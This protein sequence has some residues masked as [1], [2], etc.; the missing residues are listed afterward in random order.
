MYTENPNEDTLGV[1]PHVL[2]TTDTVSSGD[3][4]AARYVMIRNNVFAFDYPDVSA[5]NFAPIMQIKAK[6]VAILNNTAI[7]S[8]SESTNFLMISG[9]H[10]AN[11]EL[12]RN[13]FYAPNLLESDGDNHSIVTLDSTTG[14]AG[15][16]AVFSGVGE[17]VWHTNDPTNASLIRF[18]VNGTAMDIGDWN[19]ETEVAPDDSSIAVTLNTT[20][21]RPSGTSADLSNG[22]SSLPVLADLYGL[23]RP[24][25]G[26]PVSLTV[27]AV[28]RETAISG[29]G[30]ADSITLKRNGSAL[31]IWL[32][33]S[34]AGPATYELPYVNAPK[35]FVVGSGGNDTLTADTS[36]GDPVPTAGL[37]FDGGN[38]NDTATIGAGTSVAVSLFGG[39]GNDVLTGGTGDD[40]I[41]GDAGADT[42]TGGDGNDSINGGAN[43]DSLVGGVG[44]DTIYGGDGGD[45]IYGDDGNDN[46]YGENGNDVLF[47][48]SGMDTLDGG[49]ND[50]FFHSLD[51]EV[52]SLI[53]GSGWDGASADVGFMVVDATNGVEEFLV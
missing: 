17:N 6:D 41:A 44:A 52:D 14:G 12:R 15:S 26:E 32:N 28:Q 31:R 35:L 45:A 24:V 34:T 19:S 9:S 53:G 29:S 27:G 5:E 20:T 38:D 42:I 40:T 22:S 11:I 8:R 7:T 48:G 3:D 39:S 30:A 21:F 2:F 43:N 33:E 23:P 49:A 46:L 10:A 16:L 36:A 51:D 47:G 1:T 37:S 13:L 18:R 50:D 25:S 4:K